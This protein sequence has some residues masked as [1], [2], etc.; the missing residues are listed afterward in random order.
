MNTSATNIVDDLRLLAAP[1]WGLCLGLAAAFL[2]LAGLAAWVWWRRKHARPAAVLSAR[3]VEE[4]R[5]DALAELEKLRPL[6]A[7]GTSRDYAIGA[8]GVVRRYIERRFAIHAP[9][10]STEEFLEEARLSPLLDEAQRRRL[11]VFLAGCDFLKFARA[12]ADLS[13]LQALHG[14]AV[15]FVKET[16]DSGG[17]ART[18]AP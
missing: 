17:T 16:D 6:M 13:E 14:A 8:S 2:I 4:A 11:Q 7:P 12:S 5:E 18:T 15:Q 3:Q 9:R 1:A 10:R